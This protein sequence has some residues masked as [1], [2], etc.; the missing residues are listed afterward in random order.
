MSHSSALVQPASGQVYIVGRSFLRYRVLYMGRVM[1]PIDVVL[2][3]SQFTKCDWPPFW[4]SVDYVKK[5]H[6]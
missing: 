2:M 5:Y 4:R 3:A 6:Y 1:V